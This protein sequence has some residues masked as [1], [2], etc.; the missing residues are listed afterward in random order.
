MLKISIVEVKSKDRT[1]VP[2]PGDIVTAMV[3]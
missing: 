2:A 3:L 1:V